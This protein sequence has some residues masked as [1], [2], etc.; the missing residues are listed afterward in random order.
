MFVFHRERCFGCHGCVAACASTH[1][2][3]PAL[4]YRALHKLPPGDGRSQTRYLSLA[5]NHCAKA[6]CVK[7]C[8]SGAMHHDRILGLVC[9]DPERCL[10]CRYCEMACPYDAIRWDA[11]AGVVRK[12]DFCSERLA[13][14]KEP[15]C[16]ATCFSGALEHRWEEVDEEPPGCQRAAPGFTH[17]PSIRP[18][19]RFTTAI[20]RPRSAEEAP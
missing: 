5:C 3:A 18:M 16:V 20:A 7:A 8:P 4:Q 1:R 19:I 14:G 15:A 2:L 12:C 17:H 9:V 10:G 13:E 6:P 11:R